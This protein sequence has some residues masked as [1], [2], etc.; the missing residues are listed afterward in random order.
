M[1]GKYAEVT[2]SE[3]L[4]QDLLP[5]LQPGRGLLP[6]FLQLYNIADVDECLLGN[7]TCSGD[8]TV[9]LN[10]PL[11]YECGCDRGY[12]LQNDRCVGK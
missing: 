12:V 6:P 9:C 4:V 11:T 10:K 3:V 8:H 2:Y 5:L 7:T 1:L